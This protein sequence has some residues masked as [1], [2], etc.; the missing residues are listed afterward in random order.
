[1]VVIVR[2]AYSL[3]RYSTKS[4][5]FGDSQRRQDEAF[6]QFCIANK[7]TPRHDHDLKLGHVSGFS[8]KHLKG[9]LGDFLATAAAGDIPKNSVL[10]IEDFNR[11]S[12]LDPLLA[13][14]L[15]KDIV[16]ANIAIGVCSKNEIYTI[17]DL[18][19]FGK[20]TSI[21]YELQ[22]GWVDS[23]QKSRWVSESRIQARER[24][25]ATK[26]P[27]TKACP[28]WLRWVAPKNPIYVISGGVRKIL[29]H[30]GRFVLIMDC[31]NP[32]LT[33]VERAV[34]TDL[35][36]AIGEFHRECSQEAKTGAQSAGDG[37][38]GCAVFGAKE[39]VQCGN[40]LA[41][42]G[43]DGIQQPVQ[44][45]LGDVPGW[46][47]AQQL[48]RISHRL[49]RSC[50]AGQLPLGRYPARKERPALSNMATGYFLAG[51]GLTRRYPRRLC[52]ARGN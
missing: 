25:A 1:M 30:T 6:K 27:M 4:Q 42:G 22:R 38:R 34:L 23:Q 9:K 46:M 37:Q 45:G 13:D 24:S 52:Q 47:I 48:R 28:R 51:S 15:V 17:E 36:V 29:A 31:W 32:H 11:L 33:E 21:S 18:R 8:G 26:K 7:L 41:V 44:L 50:G 35:I 5:Q 10:V 49:S 12:R 16:R 39:F 43:L 40:A 14:D 2:Y 19:D 3:T 20:R